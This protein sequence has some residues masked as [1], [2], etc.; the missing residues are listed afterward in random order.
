MDKVEYRFKVDKNRTNTVLL[1]R[2]DNGTRQNRRNERHG[3]T[4][5]SNTQT[6]PELAVVAVRPGA[7]GKMIQQVLRTDVRLVSSKTGLRY[8][9]FN[10]KT[11]R[12]RLVRMLFG[13]EPSVR[14]NNKGGDLKIW[15][16]GSS[17]PTVNKKGHVVYI[18]SNQHLFGTSQNFTRAAKI[19]SEFPLFEQMMNNKSVVNVFQKSIKYNVK[20]DKSIE[21]TYPIEIQ[22]TDFDNIVGHSKVWKNNTVHHEFRNALNRLIYTK[23]LRNATKPNNRAKKQKQNNATS[24]VYILIDPYIMQPEGKSSISVMYPK[25]NTTMNRNQIETKIQSRFPDSTI[26]WTPYSI[27][28]NGR[29]IGRT[30]GIG[31]G[32]TFELL[33]IPYRPSTHLQRPVISVADL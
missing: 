9:I 7:N 21:Y 23:R 6:Y 16:V 18:F 31:K 8:K 2:T 14:N 4:R 15:I 20:P 12:R 11:E 1:E 27:G 30:G 28:S 33:H 5:V 25:T 17:L 3:K 22:D 26:E 19:L 13:S 10:D 29:L 24:A 32:A